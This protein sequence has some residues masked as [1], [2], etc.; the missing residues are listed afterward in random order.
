MS[1]HKQKIKRAT[2]M[3]TEKERSEGISIWQSAAW[4]LRKEAIKKRV[5]E[6]RKKKLDEGISVKEHG[7]LSAVERPGAGTVQGGSI[8]SPSQL[9]KMAGS[10]HFNTKAEMHAHMREMGIPVTLWEKLKKWLSKLFRRF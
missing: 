4:L 8:P 10:R 7:I 2:K 1:P 6:L 9:E 5:F 3:M